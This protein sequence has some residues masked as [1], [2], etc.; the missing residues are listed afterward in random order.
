M[1]AQ[2]LLSLLAA[3]AGLPSLQWSRDGTAALVVDQQLTLNLEHD[4]PGG[5]LLAYVVL[6][7]LPT[8]DRQA[9]AVRLLQANL[10]GSGTGGGHLGLDADEVLLS[11][12][13]ELE[14]TDETAFVAALEALIDAAQ[15]LREALLAPPAGD[16]KDP[17]PLD[18]LLRA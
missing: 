3:R 10:F 9:Q 4:E 7:T 18:A 11:R 12:T 15:S 17:M 6:G 16:D 1:H 5:R 8:A 2:D 14:H 13:L